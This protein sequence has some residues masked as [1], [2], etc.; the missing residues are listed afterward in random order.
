MGL[1]YFVYGVKV[2]D[3][4]RTRWGLLRYH[5]IVYLLRY[6]KSI[7]PTLRK[8]EKRKKFENYLD[9][10]RGFPPFFSFEAF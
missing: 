5:I 3:K 8:D 9:F 10:L 6:E 7:N 1:N 2:A 4:Y